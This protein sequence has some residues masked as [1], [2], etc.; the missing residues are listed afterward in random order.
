MR[1]LH[2]RLV[3]LEQV[4]ALPAAQPRITALALETGAGDLMFIAGGWR[5]CPDAAAVLEG[6]EGPLKVYAGFDP[7]EV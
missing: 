4:V 3:K 2:R 5:P 6:H 7:R 1:G